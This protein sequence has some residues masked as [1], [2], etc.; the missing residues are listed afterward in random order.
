[1][2]RV[3]RQPPLSAAADREEE[4]MG[5]VRARNRA[6]LWRR[7]GRNYAKESE[8]GGEQR[9]QRNARA[10][11]WDSFLK[12]IWYPPNLTN[13]GKFGKFVPV[14]TQNLNEI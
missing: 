9:T 12:K 8:Y 5:A 4:A 3:Q 14:P 11:F 10:R 13:F 6:K 2:H 7:G 1:M